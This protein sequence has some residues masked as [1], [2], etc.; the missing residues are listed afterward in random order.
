MALTAGTQ[1]GPYEI[2]SHIGAGGMGVVYKARDTRLDRYVALKL[3]PDELAQ[4][5]QALSRFR[6]EAKSASAL[7]HP[8]ICTIYD[9]GEADGHAFIAMEYLEGT[10][11]RQQIAGKAL[12]LDAALSLGIEIADALDAAHSAGI[13]HRDIKPANI[14]VT[15]RQ[16]A[17]I[18]DFGLAKV[19][20]TGGHIAQPSGATEAT[21]HAEQLTSPGAAMGTVAYMSPEQVS[22]KELD[23]RTDLFSF[24]VVLY[25][26]VTGTPPFRGQSTG[27]IFDAILN[28]APV[29]PI[30]LNP[31][32][33]PGLEEIINKALEKDRDLRYQHAADMRADLKRLKRDTDSGRSSV[34]AAAA[35]AS[36]GAGSGSGFGRVE[37]A[38]RPP[39]KLPAWVWAVVAVVVVVLVYL[40]RPTLPPPQV[41]GTTQLTQ[42]GATK[43]FGVGAIPPPLLTDGS[44]LYFDESQGPI[45]T[46]AMQV[47]T[48]GG[49]TVPVGLPPTFTG[50]DNIVPGRPE[51]LI[52]GA[53]PP[54]GSLGSNEGNALWLMSVPGG[55]PRRVGDLMATGGGAFTPDGNAMLYAFHHDIYTASLD[56]SQARKILTVNAGFPFWLRLSPDGRLLRFSVFNPTLET[57]TLWEAHADGS[58]PRPLLAGWQNPSNECCGNWTSDGNYFVFQATHE[59][60]SNLWAVR[61][62]GDLWRK[63][64]HDPVRLTVGQMNSQSPLPN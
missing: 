45:E 40:L 13:L 19:V 37:V 46:R 21:I 42:D 24:G 7:N 34:S 39:K 16:H 53:N 57:S 9:I 43:L 58:H 50:V 22:G 35:V 27:L 11:L 26:M 63:V 2:E 5:P 44:R 56:G 41:T 48:E 31:D 54:L 15:T 52:D 55:Q 29:A 10:T 51:L 8:N 32:L 47:S 20:P 12:G 60:M 62:K 1:L 33:P 30:R 17:K 18:L 61:V 6:R 64:S 4:D 28:R 36:S 3:L 14:F 49:G 38:P 23:A 25:E 59:G